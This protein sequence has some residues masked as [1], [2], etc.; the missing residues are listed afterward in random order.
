[1]YQSN[2][3]EPEFLK[4]EGREGPPTLKDPGDQQ[5]SEYNDDYSDNDSDDF[6]VEEDGAIHDTYAERETRF[7]FCIAQNAKWPESDNN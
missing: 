3:V 1:M 5:L 2:R 7:P 6:A 4:E